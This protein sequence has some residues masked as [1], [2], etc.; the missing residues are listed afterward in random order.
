MIHLFFMIIIRFFFFFLNIKILKNFKD[1]SNSK[2]F[3]QP[4]KYSV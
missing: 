4:K 3:H 1:I 2:M